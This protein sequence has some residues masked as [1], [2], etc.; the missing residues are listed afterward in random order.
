MIFELIP[1]QTNKPDE[2]NSQF[3]NNTHIE[4]DL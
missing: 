4:I 1:E 3:S 2:D